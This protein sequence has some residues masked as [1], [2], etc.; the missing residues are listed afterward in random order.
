MKKF[1]K[2]YWMK[3]KRKTDAKINLII[4]T[5]S[6]D[7]DNDIVIETDNV[8]ES[9]VEHFGD[10]L[11][12]NTKLYFDQVAEVNEVTPRGSTVQDIEAGEKLLMELEG[13]I[14]CITYPEFFL[15]ALGGLG[16]IFKSLLGILITGLISY[17]LRPKP[18]KGP[19]V[20][21]KTNKLR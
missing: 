1:A 2:L 21:S 8:L 18:P 13:D 5:T 10:K 11:P 12:D 17:L 4:R 20:P 9:L 16:G 19:A 15:F 3:L 7:T 14:Y 6:V